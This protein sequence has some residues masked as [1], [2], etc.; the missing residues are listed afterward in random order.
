MQKRN[1]RLYSILG[2][3][4]ILAM[5]MSACAP[6][7]PAG[8]SGAADAAICRATE[9]HASENCKMMTSHGVFRKR[10]Q[11]LLNLGLLEKYCRWSLS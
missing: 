5:V 6:A 10:L 8:D 2:L 3:L 4:L 1:Q 7:A 9:V 11:V